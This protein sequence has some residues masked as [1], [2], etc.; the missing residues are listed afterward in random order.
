LIFPCECNKF[1][2]KRLFSLT[3]KLMHMKKIGTILLLVGFMLP[4]IAIFAQCKK[5][6]GDVSALKGQTVINLKYDYS[7]MAVGKYKT[8]TEYMTHRVNDM[9]KKKEGDG[10]RWAIAY[11][12][13]RTEKFQPSFEK[14]L[15]A[16]LAKY[17]VTCKADAADAKY[18][19]VV[20]TTFME[21]G[22]N[23][24]VTRQNAYIKVEVDLVETA[25]PAVVIASLL[26]K[27]EDSINMMGYDFDTGS[28]VQSA[29]DRAGGH[30]G[31]FLAKNSF[32]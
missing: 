28:R 6:S 29:Y 2:P 15:N 10:D 16:S 12:A 20:R 11:K 31:S 26:M 1:A 22:Y 4:G 32:K 9:N 18:T 3:F 25:N 21:P 23:V 14:S 17:K 13:D 24:G 30:L 8:E 7:K 5:V 19:L 27:K